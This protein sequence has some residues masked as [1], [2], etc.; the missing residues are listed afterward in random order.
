ELPSGNGRRVR[1]YAHLLG[2]ESEVEATTPIAS[3]APG[4]E[5]SE[6]EWQS[7]TNERL[8]AL[9]SSLDQALAE[10]TKLKNELGLNDSE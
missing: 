2:G 4:S 8:A 7:E 6:S 3:H 10:I 5:A 9:E 1:T